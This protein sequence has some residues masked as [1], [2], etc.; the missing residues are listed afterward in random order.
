MGIKLRRDY[1]FHLNVDADPE[2]IN[3]LIDWR[4]RSPSVQKHL[5]TKLSA[6]TEG[7]FMQRQF[8]VELRVDYADPDKNDV[9][10]KALQAAARHMYATA[11]LLSDSGMKPE[12]MLCS[13]DFFSGNEEMKLLDDTIQQGLDE[14]NL[15]DEA[16]V[17]DELLRAVR[18]SVGQQ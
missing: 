6:L 16:P 15:P 3:R 5:G 1:G 18:D 17:S 12:I 13:D 10:K 8:T 9:M 14:T 2:T 7:S 4:M 11:V